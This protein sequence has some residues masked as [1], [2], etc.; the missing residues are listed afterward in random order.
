MRGWW[1]VLAATLAVLG[2]LLF[3]KPQLDDGRSCT[4]QALVILTSPDYGKSE[5]DLVL[6]ND[7][8]DCSEKAWGRIPFILGVAVVGG[9]TSAALRKR[10]H[11]ANARMRKA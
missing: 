2:G 11:P 5:T 10:S 8:T 3:T 9:G 6:S 1:I 7:K 4:D